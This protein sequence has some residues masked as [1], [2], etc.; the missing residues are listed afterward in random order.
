MRKRPEWT[1][2]Q[3]LAIELERERISTAHLTQRLDGVVDVLKECEEHRARYAEAK[4][5]QFSLRRIVEQQANYIEL[6]ER[7]IRNLRSNGDDEPSESNSD[8]LAQIEHL[9]I[10]RDT[11]RG[12]LDMLIAEKKGYTDEEEPDG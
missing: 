9:R 7:E 3:R 8:L 1:E 12:A 6:L 4:E 2:T 11:A 5:R 10:E